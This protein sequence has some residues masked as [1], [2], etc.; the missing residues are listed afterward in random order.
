YL[1]AL[2]VAKKVGVA[3]LSVED[4]VSIFAVAKLLGDHASRE[5]QL[6]VALE[7]YKFYSQYEKAGGE[8]WRTLADL[9]ERKATLADSEGKPAEYQDSLFSSLWCTE[10][11]LSYSGLSAD[12]DLLGRKDRYMVSIT[13]DEVKKRW[14][15]IRLWFD[16]QYSLD[17][18]RQ[19]LGAG[20][21]DLDALD[22]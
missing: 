8:T 10:P 3:N 9:F 13:A 16:V 21:M 4:K 11:A 18:T 1:L 6:D 20:A 15:G 5:N 2:R 7:A 12:K 17:K 14:E 19:V 22:W